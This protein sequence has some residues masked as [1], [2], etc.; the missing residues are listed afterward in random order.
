MG[1]IEMEHTV[2]VR[3]LS[4]YLGRHINVKSKVVTVYLNLPD[5]GYS[6]YTLVSERDSFSGNI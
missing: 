4:P 1:G 2:D 3:E 6:I 5:I